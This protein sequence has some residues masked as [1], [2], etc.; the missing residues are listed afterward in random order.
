MR[1]IWL[2][3][4]PPKIHLGALRALKKYP[5]GN[6]F[7]RIHHLTW[8]LLSNFDEFFVKLLRGSPNPLTQYPAFLETLMCFKTP[9][10]DLKDMVSLDRVQD[11][12]SQQNF[13]ESFQ[14]L[15]LTSWLHLKLCQE[16]LCSW[17]LKIK[18]LDHCQKSPCPSIPFLESWWTLEVPEKA[19]NCVRG[20]REPLGSF[21][22]N[23]VKIGQVY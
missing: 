3:L 9:E 7:S 2:L 11:V 20:L 8:I 5:K 22:K 21:T 13:Q 14:G 18:H 10:R 17:R 1:R 19:G 6:I 16:P 4:D 12:W 23:F 15:L